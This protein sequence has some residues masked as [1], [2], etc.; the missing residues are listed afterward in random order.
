MSRNAPVASKKR[1]RG[2]LTL[3]GHASALHMVFKVFRVVFL[4]RCTA[5]TNIVGSCRTRLQVLVAET[6]FFHLQE[7]CSM[8]NRAIVVEYKY[9]TT[10]KMKM[11]EKEYYSVN[12]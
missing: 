5:G 3:L 4:P 12:C 11:N 8:R 2:R 10:N 9:D 7:L 6:C 1:L